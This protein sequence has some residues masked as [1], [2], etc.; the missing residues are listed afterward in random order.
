MKRLFVFGL[1]YSGQYIARVLAERRFIVT[2]TGRGGTVDFGDVSAVREGLARA[3]HVLS[4]VPPHDDGS[5]P[6]LAR[7]GPYLAGRWFGYLSSTGVYGDTGGAWVDESAPVG[8]GRRA[9][10]VAADAAWR[11]IGGR[12][13]RLPGIYGPGRSVFDRFRA[14]TAQR[15]VAPRQ[16]TLR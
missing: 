5:D 11:G 13:F 2:G 14:G 10:R 12:V 4:C 9:A 8:G 6:V 3:T 16:S 15:I 7:Y 1:G